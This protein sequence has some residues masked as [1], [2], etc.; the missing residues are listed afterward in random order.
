VLATGVVNAAREL[1]LKIPIVVRMEGTNVERGRQ[2]LE[3]SG[4]NF[5]VAT[6]MKD[7]AEKAVQLAQ[8]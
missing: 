7:G 2:I 8:A 5:A 4:L 3:E 1:A 6:G